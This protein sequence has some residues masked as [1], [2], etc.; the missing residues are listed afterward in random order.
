MVDWSG[1]KEGGGR[2]RCEGEGEGGRDVR[3]R[4]GERGVM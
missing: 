2:E 3:E 1:E 4:R